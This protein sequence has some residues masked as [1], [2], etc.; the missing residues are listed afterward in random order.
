[1]DLKTTTLNWCLIK[2]LTE[3]FKIALFLLWHP[4]KAHEREREIKEQFEPSTIS[5]NKSCSALLITFH[6]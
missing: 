5:A 4:V 6:Y 3:S 2:F 1:M